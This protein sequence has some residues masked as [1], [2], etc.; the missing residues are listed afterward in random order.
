VQRLLAP[1]TSKV[2]PGVLPPW[3]ALLDSKC[4]I[5]L[6]DFQSGQLVTIMPCSWQH[7]MCHG[8]ACQTFQSRAGGFCPMCR[9][10]APLSCV[11]EATSRS[12]EVSAGAGAGTVPLLMNAVRV[13]T[14]VLRMNTCQSIPSP[15]D[16]VLP[17]FPPLPCLYPALPLALLQIKANPR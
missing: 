8:C 12:V 1:W 17:S 13:Y 15:F 10:V 3:H 11:N 14:V 6:G 16:L 2:T 4:C 7:A 5:C 9:A